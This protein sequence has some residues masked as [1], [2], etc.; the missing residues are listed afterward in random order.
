MAEIS[1]IREAS[2]GGPSGL[3]PINKNAGTATVIHGI[4]SEELPVDG[5]TIE[6]VRSRFGD[7]LSLHPDRQATINGKPVA[8]D[9][10]ISSGE[11]L[12]FTHLVGSKGAKAKTKLAIE[13]RKITATSP[14]GQARSIPLDRFMQLASPM[15][16]S[17]GSIIFPD[18]IKGAY[19]DG[20][21]MVLM[22]QT[23][24]RMHYFK[25]ISEDSVEK[26]GSDAKYKKVSIALPYLVT[27]AV[28][29]IGSDGTVNLSEKSE[30]FFS[31][32]PIRSVDDELLYPA[33][34]NVS[35][36]SASD[37]ERAPL[38]WIC[39]QY[40]KN[41][42]GSADANQSVFQLLGSLVN[43]LLET[44]FNFSSEYNEGA[45]WFGETMKAKV[46]PRIKDVAT[47]EQSSKVDPLFALEVPWIKTGYTVNTLQERIFKL[48]SRAAVFVSRA[49]DA[50]R[51]V[52]NAR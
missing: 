50:A 9:Y 48:N 18:G 51:I 41:R 38:A 17:S 15:K 8:N 22:H 44:G 49:S 43:C 2:S 30:C 1:R 21:L 35:K 11:T 31:N 16:I 5:M 25:W 40:L 45:S 4:M 33:L 6:Q 47:W 29:Q 28:F 36:F 24:P 52:F 19:S 39:V 13:G 34:L 23:P 7:R 26:F 37:Q 12:L 20:R 42:G 46:D 32:K 10:K 14:E 27:M 3:P